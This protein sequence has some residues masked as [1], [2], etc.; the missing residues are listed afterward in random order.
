MRFFTVILL[1][2]V[3]GGAVAFAQ[4]M[5]QPLMATK[6]TPAVSTS[7]CGEATPTQAVNAGFT[8]CAVNYD[9]SQP[10]YATLSNWLDCTPPYN[11]TALPWHQGGAGQPSTGGAICNPGTNVRVVNDPSIGT[12]VLDMTWFPSYYTGAGN[13]NPVIISTATNGWNGGQPPN[14]NSATFSVPN[15]T[16]IQ[17]VEKLTPASGS[18]GSGPNGLWSW[19]ST[20]SNAG[21][22]ERDFAEL[23]A[24]PG[25]GDMN[26]YNWGNNSGPG[27]IWC[28]YNGCS[29]VVGNTVIPAGYASSAYHTYST[30]LTTDGS[31]KIYGC[32]WIDTTFQA[33][34]NDAATSGQYAN[35]IF[36]IIDAVAAGGSSGASSPQIDLDVA[37]IR[38]W[39]CAS[40][41]SGQCNG[42][43]LF[44]G[45]LPN[46]TYW[47]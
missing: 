15:G 20:P 8:T 7:S 12:N 47:H 33:C 9:F 3:L 11:N 31:T 23:Y 16:F 46:L 1:A 25:I 5:G 38:V 6:P 18:G 32:S 34:W 39:S 2:I 13:G 4:M 36:L 41:A 44:G 45:S 21:S 42:A 19:Q 27:A 17:T 29:E 30:L 43:T 24:N 28:D 26:S 40:W 37:S 35:R 14:G 10:F 22:L